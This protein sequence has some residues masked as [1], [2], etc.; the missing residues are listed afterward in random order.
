MKYSEKISL[1][2]FFPFLVKI[3]SNAP[4]LL[5]LDAVVKQ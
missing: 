5:I 4:G 1:I 2:T 3:L